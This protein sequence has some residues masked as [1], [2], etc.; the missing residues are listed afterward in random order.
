MNRFPV[1]KNAII[2]IALVFGLLYTLP[3]FFGE[4]PAVQVSSVKATVKVDTALL[5]RVE[6]TLATAGIAH[7]GL[8]AD[9][10]SVRVRFTDTDTQLKAKDAIEKALNPDP[11]DASYSV[12]LNLLSASPSWL[13][14]IHA[15]PMYLGLDLRGGVHF[16]LQVDMKGAITKRLD[17]TA[18]DLRSQ[19][20]DKNIR[21]SGI[22]REHETIVVRFRDAETRDKA[23]A[24]IDG[25]QRTAPSSS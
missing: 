5:S 7:N 9:L 6:G 17:S 8:F 15:L 10:N 25:A 2:V 14:G 19:L 16:L 11:T 4:V 13:T 23:K 3:N 12:A 22:G 24:A 20:R 18:A 1:W 21:H